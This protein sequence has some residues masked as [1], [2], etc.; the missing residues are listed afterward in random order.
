MKG[1]LLYNLSGEKLK[2][3]RVILL[4]LGMQGRVITPEE[5]SLPV[6]QLAGV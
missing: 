2:K 4:R 6:G 1:V 5:F 3:I